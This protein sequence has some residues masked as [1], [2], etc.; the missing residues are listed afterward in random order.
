MGLRMGMIA[1]ISQREWLVRYVDVVVKNL[2]DMCGTS[3]S[4][5]SAAQ[6][7]LRSGSDPQFD[8]VILDVSP[9]MIPSLLP[10]K[11][12]RA[13]DRRVAIVTV[14]EV[15]V[16]C[17][18]LQRILD[19]GAD[20]FC[21]LDSGA[22]GLNEVIS[23]AIGQRRACDV[24]D[25]E[26]YLTPIIKPSWLYAEYIAQETKAGWKR[27]ML[28][29]REAQVL[30][31]ISE[32]MTTSEI[33]EMLDI[34]YSTVQVYRKRLAMKLETSS[35]ALQTRMAMRLMLTSLIPLEGESDAGLKDS[36][37]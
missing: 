33:A 37:G 16:A 5:I 26:R 9:S 34:R 18:L 3:H 20:G 2:P 17:S 30:S 7:L 32:G 28:S 1:I 8:C 25:D 29:K 14:S 24:I 35:P 21:T 11:R 31:L 15:P 4:Y 27:N 19:A 22:V 13:H 10:I 36:S 23:L 6:L 12:L